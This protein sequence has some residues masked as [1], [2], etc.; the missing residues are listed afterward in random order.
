MCVCTVDLAGSTGLSTVSPGDGT[1]NTAPV[2]LFT[3]REIQITTQGSAADADYGG[4]WLGDDDDDSETKNALDQL[5]SAADY[6][7]KIVGCLSDCSLCVLQPLLLFTSD[8]GML[9][10]DCWLG[11]SMKQVCFFN[12]TVCDMG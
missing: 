1:P 2:M 4:V 3:Q 10:L 9:N 6:G 8:F 7:G 12:F 11:E 5:Q